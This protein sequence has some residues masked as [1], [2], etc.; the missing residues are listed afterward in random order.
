MS[1]F[2]ICTN[3]RG[4]IILLLLRGTHNAGQNLNVGISVFLIYE[5]GKPVL[6]QVS[7][8]KHVSQ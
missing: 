7:K 6:L 4:A 8:N 1:L 2:T 3:S 5:T